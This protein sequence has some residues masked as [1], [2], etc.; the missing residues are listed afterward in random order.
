MSNVNGKNR[1]CPS[2]LQ[3]ELLCLEEGLSDD[4]KKRTQMHLQQCEQC[5]EKGRYLEAFYGILNLEISKSIS[6]QVLDFAKS[7]STGIKY[8]MLICEP[9]PENKNGHGQAFLA[10][11]VFVANGKDGGKKLS[12]YDLSSIPKYDIALRIMT[13]HSCNGSLLCIWNRNDK[14]F[15][16]WKLHI[17][18]M[19]EDVQF[20]TIGVARVSEVNIEKLDNKVIF[21]DI[22]LE[23]DKE[24]T[25]F[26][27][28][29]DTVLI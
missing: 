1:I 28:I 21:F 16:D 3:L 10:K 22:S 20:N 6:N 9:I 12:D 11:L 18:G 26:Q 29:K 27:R 4:E 13:D 23:P 24:T 2:E 8:G 19:V 7:L 25:R 17:P 14:D 15:H 5:R